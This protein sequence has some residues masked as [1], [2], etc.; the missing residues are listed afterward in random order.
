MN[1]N[2]NVTYF[3]NPFDPEL[4]SAYNKHVENDHNTRI[5]AFMKFENDRDLGISDNP[6]KYN[7]TNNII[8]FNGLHAL[9]IYANT[10]CP[11]SQLIDAD[12]LEELQIKMNEMV[13][14]FNN[15]EFIQHLYDYM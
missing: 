5:Y 7:N 4:E 2:N 9:A 8:L 12:S 3:N 10:P 13:E 14:N 11:A 1:T 15:H 6:Y